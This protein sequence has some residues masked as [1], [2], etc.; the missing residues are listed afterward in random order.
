MIRA[1]LTLAF[2]PVLFVAADTASRVAPN[3]SVTVV[4]VPNGGLQPEVAVDSAGVVHMVYL[5]GPPAAANVFY[6][7]SSDGGQTFST[8]VRVNS[9]EGSAI[10]AGTIR[11]AQIAIGRSGTVHVAWNGSEKALPRGPVNPTT[12]R[13]SSP[14]L[15]T[16]ASANGTA[17]EPQRN[18]MFRTTDLD[19]GG[20]V[21]ADGRG[22]VFVAWHGQDE[23]GSGGEEARRVWIARSA[24][25]GVTFGR[26]AAVSDPATGVCG[27]CAL[28]L[29]AAP[30]GELRLLYRSATNRMN[31]DVYSLVS[32]DMGRT[33][34]GTR[35]HGW[36][37]NACPMT[38]MSIAAGPALLRAW[39]T[40]GQVYY[41]A[42][43][44]AAAT[45]PPIE[46]GNEPPRRKHPRLAANP[47]RR[48]LLVWTDGTAWG[49]GGSVGWQEFDAEGRPTTIKGTVAGLPAWSFASTIVRPDGSYRIFY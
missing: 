38:S 23:T 17:F 44:G 42:G 24:D 25:D 5:A 27:C 12:K 35:T 3:G 43:T 32:R 39:E 15:Y 41:S 16:R 14:M 37:I 30:A 46:P 8:A 7:R 1:L 28:R 22:N 21:A 19:G 18:L 26:E 31:R 9:Q 29:V 2:F 48:V 13:A 49:R 40:D 10:A 33:F 47:D 20:S 45:F 36:E 11:G 6:V 4:R 34:T